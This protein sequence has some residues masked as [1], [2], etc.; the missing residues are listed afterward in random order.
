M[1]N[2]HAIQ[3]RRPSDL[4]SDF[5]Q[6]LYD[7]YNF[8]N[9]P[10]TIRYLLSGIGQNHIPSPAFEGLHD[11]YDSVILLYVDAFGWRFFEQF[12]DR[13]PALQHIMQHGVASRITAQFPST[14]AAHTTAIHTGL[15]P[16]QS[17]VYEW[18]IY[19]PGVDAIIAPLLFS[20]AGESQREQLKQVGFAPSALFPTQT[21]YQDLRRLGVA[22][23]IYQR[24]DI[25]YTSPGTVLFD[26]AKRIF[27]YAT[28]TEAF[29]NISKRLLKQNKPTY[30]FVYYSPIDTIGHEYGPESV[31]FEAEIDTFLTTLQ[32]QLLDR[33]AGKQRQRVL[34]LITSD[35]GQTKVSPKTTFYINQEIPGFRKYIAL[36]RQGQL[37]VP[38]GSPRDLFLHIRPELLD[39]AHQVLSDQIIGKALVVRTSELIERGYFGPLPISAA[40]RNR[41]ANLCVLPFKGESAYWYV[42]GK[43]EQRHY[44]HHGGLTPDEME[45]PLLACEL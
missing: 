31:E 13:A 43:Y 12:A 44:G 15:P 30:Y 6:P 38:A 39:E 11:R 26:G 41:V 33:A 24:S 23:H 14:T 34:L 3:A 2:T 35:H 9:L 21:I 7:S 5:V 36:N 4:H 16:S 28:L 27:G 25:A 20:F 29:V 32:R 18:Y 19:E 45:I 42:K 8:V 37:L 40:L 10:G 1:L 17:G 22:S